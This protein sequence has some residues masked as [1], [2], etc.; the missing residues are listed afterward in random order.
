MLMASGWALVLAALGMLSA[1]GP[2]GVFALAGIA[3]Q[4][5]GLVL[6]VR[7]HLPPKNDKIPRDG[8]MEATR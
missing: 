5:L 1:P 3:V 8:R 4:I 6:T 7:A 2:R